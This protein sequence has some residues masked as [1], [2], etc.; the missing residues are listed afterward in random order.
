MIDVPTPNPQSRHLSHVTRHFPGPIAIIIPACDEEECIGRVLDERLAVV[1]P[2]K[3]FVAI[4]V[5]GSTDRTAEIAQSRG[6]WA[7]ET[8]E[9]GYGYGCQAAI[10]LIT[11]ARPQVR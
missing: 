6:V 4:G 7:A 8:K 2:D 3:F 11:T 9:R 10:D 1:D 5:N